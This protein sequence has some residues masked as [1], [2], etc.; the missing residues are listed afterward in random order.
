MKYQTMFDYF[1]ANDFEMSITVKSE[2]Q[3]L[4]GAENTSPKGTLE[5]EE[6][7]EE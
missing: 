3:S 2:P 5:I 6:H 1:D 7:K 4:G